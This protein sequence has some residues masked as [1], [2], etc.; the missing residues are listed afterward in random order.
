[1]QQISLILND[2]RG[3][4][5]AALQRL[6]RGHRRAPDPITLQHANSVRGAGDDGNTDPAARDRIPRGP[7]VSVLNGDAEETIMADAVPADRA[8]VRA[9][10][11]VDADIV[12]EYVVIQDLDTT[13]PDVSNDNT[14][15]LEVGYRIWA[16]EGGG[17]RIASDNI[18]R[19]PSDCIL[20]D[21][22]TFMRL[23]K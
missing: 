10:G 13:R 4:E 11:L 20:S 12:G 23:N 2:G 21:R 7:A 14:R 3:C 17:A 9:C 19:H 8:A 5:P 6:D 22:D 18:L 1:M 16:A 15:R